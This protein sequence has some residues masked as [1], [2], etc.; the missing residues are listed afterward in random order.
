MPSFRTNTCATH[1][2]PEPLSGPRGFR[3]LSSVLFASASF[4][5]PSFCPNKHDF[6][7][8]RLCYRRS[9]R[10]DINK[11]TTLLSTFL[12]IKNSFCRWGIKSSEKIFAGKAELSSFFFFFFFF[13]FFAAFIR[14]QTTG[15]YSLTGH[16][17]YVSLQNRQ[18]TARSRLQN[19][20]FGLSS[21]GSFSLQNYST[22]APR[23]TKRRLK[24]ATMALCLIQCRNIKTHVAVAVQRAQRWGVEGR[25]VRPSRTA[26]PEGRQNEYLFQTGEKNKLLLGQM[27]W[28]SMIDS[29]R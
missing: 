15:N 4:W 25:L 16:C 28:N 9:W 23:H 22:S 18:D 12:C 14:P 5:W 11:L 24:K 6:P 8:H 2:G 13:F 29:N 20:Q 17:Q 1:S 19:T 3:L 21:L 26:E 7:E 10:K 27:N